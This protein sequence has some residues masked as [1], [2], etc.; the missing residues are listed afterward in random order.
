MAQ[1]TTYG[2]TKVNPPSVSSNTRPLSP[3]PSAGQPPATSE[4]IKHTQPYP[5]TPVARDDLFADLKK[6]TN[7]PDL[8]PIRPGPTL[9]DNLPGQ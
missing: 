7:N 9:P 3:P 1:S 5:T 8:R 2:S 4:A 6:M